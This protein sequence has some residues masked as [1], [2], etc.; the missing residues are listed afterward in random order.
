MILKFLAQHECV[1]S[2]LEL[3]PKFGYTHVKV[4]ITAMC[5]GAHLGNGDKLFEQFRLLYNKGYYESALEL[6][7]AFEMLPLSLITKQHLEIASTRMTLIGTVL[8]QFGLEEY[9]CWLAKRSNIKRDVI[10]GLNVLKNFTQIA[11]NVH[12]LIA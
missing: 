8:M 9:I 7:Y 5:D 4:L 1:N 12:L 6:C 11:E 2:M 3:I 10:L